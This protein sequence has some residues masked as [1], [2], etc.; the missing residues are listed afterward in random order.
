MRGNRRAGC[1]H[2]AIDGSIP[3]CAGEPSGKCAFTRMLRVYPRVCGGTARSITRQLLPD[4]LSPRVR[5]NLP[6]IAFYA[7]QGGSI[8]ACAGEPTAL[9]VHDTGW[10]VYPR[11]CGGTRWQLNS[12]PGDVGL[13]PRVR[14]NLC[15]DRDSGNRGGSIPACAG[16]P[17]Y[18]A[19]KR[20]CLRVYPRVC[21]GTH[22][23]TPRRTRWHGL[24]PRV[25]GNP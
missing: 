24:S 5:G 14:G 22:H 17:R 6:V 15:L 4:G 12:L 13:S 18:K 3:A 11:V 10:Q 20:T 23:R 19:A 2:S 25:R 8:P 21:G 16:E 9:E 7:S 1:A